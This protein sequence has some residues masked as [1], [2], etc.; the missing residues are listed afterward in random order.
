MKIPVAS[1]RVA[2]VRKTEGERRKKPMRQ[3]SEIKKRASRE[4]RFISVDRA[5]LGGARKS[6][7]KRGQKPCPAKLR[8]TATGERRR[9]RALRSVVTHVR[10]MKSKET[11][12]FSTTQK[13]PRAFCA[14]ARKFGQFARQSIL[15]P[16]SSILFSYN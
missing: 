9:E 10:Q 15:S 7:A 1:C 12:L 2:S 4:K 8:R 6:S 11:V 13:Y 14:F 16:R 5:R 3:R